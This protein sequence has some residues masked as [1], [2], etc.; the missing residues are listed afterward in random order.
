[1][2]KAIK[3]GAM[4]GL[5]VAT[6]ITMA[7][8]VGR[9][10][11]LPVMQ[12]YLKTASNARGTPVP[13]QIAQLLAEANAARDAGND[14]SALK[15][16]DRVLAIEP[17]NLAARAGRLLTVSRLGAPTTALAE[18]KLWPHLDADVLQRLHED[19]AAL[20]IRRTEQIYRAQPVEA[21]A[22]ADAALR[23]IE[24]NLKRNPRSERTRFDYVRA[25]SNRGRHRD[26]I[27]QYEALVREKRMLPGYLHR[28]AG[29]SYLAEQA[30][31]LAVSAY[32]DAL[33]RDSNDFEASVGLFYAL[34][35]LNQYTAAHRHI[36]KLAAH[37]LPPQQKFEAEIHA[38]WAHAFEG[39]L[40]RAQAEFAALQ[41][42][43]PASAEVH[44]AL[45][46]IYLWRGWPRRAHDEYSLVAQNDKHDIGAHAGLANTDVMLGAFRSAA[47]RVAIL[48]AVAPDVPVVKQVTRAQTVR[49]L[50]ELEIASG[51]SRTKDRSSQ[52]QSIYFDARVFSRPLAFQHRLFART[53]YE[54][55]RFS[56][57][58]AYYKRLGV[59]V[60]STI[61][62]HARLEA[63]VQ[64][65]FFR[66]DRVGGSLGGTFALDDRWSVQARF[67]SNSVDVP[68]QARIDDIH[69]R[70]A[71]ARLQYRRDQRTGAQIGG[72]ELDMSDSNTRR[73]GI[74]SAHHK[75]IEG[76]FYQATVGIDVGASSNTRANATYFNPRR[77]RTAQI[78]L[79]NEWL[80]YRRYTRAFYQRVQ[81][82]GGSY[83]QQDFGSNTIGS[84]RYEHDWSFSDTARLRYSVGYAQR[85]FDG[86]ASKGA[87]ASLSLNWKF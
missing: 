5:M 43:A 7:R 29:D 59:G 13:A 20:A 84:A 72:Q 73:S 42:R 36:D 69:G 28:A 17:A 83:R 61:A 38:A 50:H 60:E 78:S 9:E 64:Q 18:A 71:Q 23:L 31:E 58:Q 67:D 46:Q 4:A 54:Q 62:R 79:A 37:P 65:E 16:Y 52:G 33:Q 86:V 30:P 35:D 27:V 11:E 12:P 51:S 77:D 22:D 45:G 34:S 76:P 70:A 3:L 80:G 44:N 2:L 24:K 26:A 81:L 48:N 25:L 8:S 49:D 74:L 47:D 39:R 15:A 10:N 82:A 19:E 75:V 87:E 56:D 21:R 53:H 40:A 85:A 55:A 66:R 63:E 14:V 41:A 57:G 68:L 6:Q 1:M 32:K